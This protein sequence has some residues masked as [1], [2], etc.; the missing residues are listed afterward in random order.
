MKNS[1]DTI[2]NRSRDLPVCSAVP[3]PLRHRV[4]LVSANAS[5]NARYEQLTGCLIVMNCLTVDDGDTMILRRG[6]VRS[7]RG[8]GPTMTARGQ[9]IG[10]SIGM[11]PQI[12]I[13]SRL[14]QLSRLGAR[15]YCCHYS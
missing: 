7:T 3:Q 4:P 8:L 15:I 5:D 6:G 14:D 11:L 12:L 2:G 10:I 13:M 9:C 1:N